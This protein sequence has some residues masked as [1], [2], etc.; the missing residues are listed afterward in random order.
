MNSERKLIRKEIYT[1][2]IPIILENIFQVSASLVSTAMI[3]RLTALDISSQGLVMRITET[4]NTFFRGVAIGSTVYISKSFGEGNRDR[5]YNICRQTFIFTVPIAIIC[6]LILFSSPTLFLRFLTHDPFILEKG[7][8]YMRIVVCGLPFVSIM[9]INT[10]AFQGH[11]DTKTPMYIAI[12]VNIVNMTFGYIFIF[13]AFGIK[14]MG[15]IGA[16]IA[17]VV[18]QIVGAVTGICLLFSKKMNIFTANQLKGNFLKYDFKCIGEIY[19]TGIP[20][21]LENIFWQLSAIIM[22]KAIMFYGE[23]CF[24]AY[25]IGIQA[26]TITEMPALGFGVAATALSAKAIGMRDEKLFKNYFD[27][28][29]KSCFI[30]SICTSLL[31]IFCPTLFMSIMTTDKTIQ[32]IG[33]LYVFIMGFVQ[34]PQNLSRIY[35]GTLRS[36]GYKK[37]PMMISG[38]GIWI[39]RIPLSLLITY[40]MSRESGIQIGRAHV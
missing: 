10:S 36:M 15:I 40:V 26:E 6:G 8:A 24:A 39:V 11:S 32:K 34:I 4:L 7:K 38:I 12:L 19:S 25:Q 16:A 30:I 17:L 9:A 1:L 14:P 22:S 20:A 35:N 27:E 21:A 13:G 18:A 3:G 29:R 33:A 37:A 5:C 31:L 23:N 28:L 2:V